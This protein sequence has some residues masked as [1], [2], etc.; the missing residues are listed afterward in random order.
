MSDK[1]TGLSARE[2]FNREKVDTILN[3][4]KRLVS[5][6]DTPIK[7]FVTNSGGSYS[8]TKCKK[9]IDRLMELM[10][11]YPLPEE[12]TGCLC[13]LDYRGRKI[14]L[15]IDD[16]AR[17][18]CKSFFY[19]SVRT[20]LYE[21]ERSGHT[22]YLENIIDDAL[23]VSQTTCDIPVLANELY[24]NL[25][26]CDPFDTR[27]YPLYVKINNYYWFLVK[28]F[29]V[30]GADISR[31]ENSGN[32]NDKAHAELLR[33]RE[34]HIQE[35]LSYIRQKNDL[36][37][38]FFDED[39]PGPVYNCDIDYENEAYDVPEDSPPSLYDLDLYH[40]L[41]EKDSYIKNCELFRFYMNVPTGYH[42]F[43]ERVVYAVDRFISEN[44]LSKL[45]DRKR[46]ATV[47]AVL[48]KAERILRD[49]ILS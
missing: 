34:D 11:D 6:R 38:S 1:K 42:R 39:G 31:Y 14:S 49:D 30:A 20:A 13:Y 3:S 37:E 17:I 22:A 33:A 9:F 25:N 27:D 24:Q 35:E 32:D 7:Q 4:I 5:G 21:E 36:E 10:N 28:T 8:E 19:C 43:Y 26:I 23:S 41:K 40:D 18:F 16:D 2:K 48:N 15:E 46:T 45:T 29:P 12:D 44:D 47:C